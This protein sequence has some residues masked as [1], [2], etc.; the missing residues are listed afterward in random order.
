MIDDNFMHLFHIKSKYEE[1]LYFTSST[2]QI[3]HE[4]KIYVPFSGLSI[5]SG[6][7]NDSA[8]NEIILHGIFEEQGI[9]ADQDLVGS[10]IKIINFECGITNELVTYICTKQIS[11]GLEFKLV[12]QPEIIKLNQSLLP[13]FSKKCRANFCDKDCKLD[14]NNFKIEILVVKMEGNSLFCADLSKHKNNYFSGGKLFVARDGR[15]YEYDIKNHFANK[16]ELLHA[17]NLNIK[18][19][20]KFYLAPTCDKKIRTCCYSFN[21]TV[22]FRGEPDIPEHRIIKN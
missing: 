15:Q 18:D 16:I 22:N 9:M 2:F 13:V 19:V 5:F 21:N 7:F 10:V 8:Q 1:E 20:S 14:I 12:C 4:D 17:H 6:E 11:E 3:N